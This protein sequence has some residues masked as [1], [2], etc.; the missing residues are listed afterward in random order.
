[1]I[2]G[3]EEGKDAC[4]G[5]S[6]SPL[7][8]SVNGRWTVIGLVSWGIGCGENNKPSVYTKVSAFVNWINQ[9]GKFSLI[10]YTEHFS[11]FIV[12]HFCRNRMLAKKFFTFF[13]K[14]LFLKNLIYSGPKPIISTTPSTKTRIKARILNDIGKLPF[15]KFWKNM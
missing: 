6:G 5:S 12:H 8:V 13:G 14:R 1:M 4:K 2:C 3:G 9:F 15:F 7:V 10:N 11:H